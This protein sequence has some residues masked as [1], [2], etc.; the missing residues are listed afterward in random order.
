MLGVGLSH[1]LQQQPGFLDVVDVTAVGRQHGLQ[2][3]QVPLGVH[4]CLAAHR[5]GHLSGGNE[6]DTCGYRSVRFL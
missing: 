2:V 1:G 5:V 4:Y 3:C 6:N